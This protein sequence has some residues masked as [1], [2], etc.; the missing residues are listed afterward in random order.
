MLEQLDEFIYDDV[1]FYLPNFENKLYPEAA[2][3]NSP[4][5]RR[6]KRIPSQNIKQFRS[7]PGKINKAI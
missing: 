3:E 2:G 5:W 6:A 1:D 4:E 7:F